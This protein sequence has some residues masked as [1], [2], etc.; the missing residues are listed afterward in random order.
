MR[1][2]DIEYSADGVRMIGQFAWDEQRAGGRPGVLVVHEG[3]GLNDHTKK[4]AQRLAALGYAALAMDYYGEGKPLANPADS[5]Q[6]L[7]PWR[8]DPTG[9]QVRATAALDVLAMRPE[10][11][12]SKLAAIGY[13]WGGTTALELGRIGADLKAIVG[14]H[15][16]LYTT[17]PQDA[18][19]IRAK[20]LVHI[21]AEDPLIPPE[22]RADFEKEMREG[23]VD[24]RLSLYGGVGHSFTNPDIDAR[25]MP[26]FRFHAPTDRRSWSAMIEL[27]NEVFGEIK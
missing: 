4:I 25:N 12:S 3:N 18:R 20:V 9:I 2:E 17:H 14:F 23:G 1:T 11:D 16:G 24:W 8:A 10:T 22:Q 7:P 26:G 13:C 21:G 5:A 6:R 15:C 19:N 27:F